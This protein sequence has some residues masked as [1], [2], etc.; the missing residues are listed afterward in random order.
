[1]HQKGIDM[2]GYTYDFEESNLSEC[3]KATLKLN[4][5]AAENY[6][7]NSLRSYIISM[8]EE[9]IITM[10]REDNSIP[11]TYVATMGFV[12]VMCPPAE[13]RKIWIKFAIDPFIL[14]M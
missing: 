6:N 2:N 3:V 11:P 5:Y 7:E 4:S 1:V 13:D 9:A 10:I 14:F 12:I 8:I